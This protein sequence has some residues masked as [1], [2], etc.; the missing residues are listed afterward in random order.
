MQRYLLLTG[1]ACFLILVGLAS[2]KSELLTIAIPIVVYLIL[3]LIFAPRKTKLLI[4]RSIAP[5]RSTSDFPIQ[6]SL[7]ITNQGDHLEEIM[8]KDLVP[9]QL[10]KIDGDCS[11]FT[12][13]DA[14]SKVEL[15]YSLRGGRGVYQFPGVEVNTRDRLGI[16]NHQEILPAPG[17]VL[18]LPEIP[19]LRGASIRPRHTKVY[20]GAIPARQGGEGIEFFGVRDYQLGDSLRQINWHASARYDERLFSNEYQLERVA[21]IW[22]ILDARL[23]SNIQ[24]NGK[25]LFEF[26]VNAAAG[27]THVLLTQGNRLGLLVY[28]G[29]LDWT[30]PGYGK[31]QIERIIR[32][33]SR[34]KPGESMVFDKLEN[35]PTRVFPISSQLILISPLNNED[36][37]ILI[38]LRA[39]GYQVSCIVPD[40]IMFERQAVMESYTGELGIR[41]AKL[42][43]RLLLIKLRQAGVQVHVWDVNTPF[44]RAM[45]LA[46][47]RIDYRSHFAGVR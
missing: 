10:R 1:L 36:L 27:L 35:L 18:V 3:G 29:Y 42:E 43:R 47:R 20:S 37:S 28:G 25:A 32:A 34:S 13:L 2:L 38:H 5:Q 40:P 33:L 44:D 14:G 16:F 26:S 45:D 7:E 4:T 30:Y 41:L 46:F 39:R 24:S 9:S 22:V 21:D 23:R 6:V 15:S 19:R 12:S 31:I 8:L 17:Q 11:L